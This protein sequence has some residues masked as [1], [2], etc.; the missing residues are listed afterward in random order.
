MAYG[1]YLL[2]AVEILLRWILKPIYWLIETIIPSK[3]ITKN[4]N[5][6]LLISATSLANKIRTKQLTSEEIVRAYIQRINEVNPVLNAV[7]DNRYNDAIEEARCIDTAIS[8]NNLAIIKTNEEKPL[9]G[10]PMTVKESCGVAGLSYCV[11]L[12]SRVNLKCVMDG[13]AVKLLRDAGAI[14]LAVTTTPE[15]CLSWETINTVTGKT[16]NPYNSHRT[17]GGSSGGE[18]ALLGAGASVIGV[19][20]DIAGSI[21]VPCQFNGIFGHKP[22]G[23]MVSVNGH[24]PSTTDEKFPYYLVLGPMTRYAEDLRLM[25]KVMSGENRHVLDLNSKVNIGD[26]N[27]FYM[28]ELG[29]KIYDVPV[30]NDIKL[31]IRKCATHLEQ[32][33]GATINKTKFIE[34]H[35]SVELSISVFFS[36]LQDIPNALQN[37]DNPKESANLM[38]EILKSLFFLSDHSLHTLFFYVLQKTNSFIPRSKGP[39][40]RR[41][42]EEAENKIESALGTNGVLLFPT[43]P[44]SAFN[45]YGLFC[46]MAGVSYTMIF[47]LMGFP[48]THVPTGMGSDNLPVGFQVIAA[49]NQDKLCLTIA[50]ELEKAFGGWIPPPSINTN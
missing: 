34:L 24:Y 41:M 40:Y 30:Q 38:I 3:R 37:P 22:T 8:E 45:H 4:S 43:F 16:I 15:L 42:F 6:L 47:N 11:G 48:S 20:S 18:G 19:G 36:V 31:A 17:C 39:M 2:G 27:I 10:V 21:R 46:N 23:A 5:K 25:L 44:V 28:E 29:N 7:V 49:R 1:I 12:R 32:N 13:E 35:D 14:I 26:L 50:E 9:L 33:C